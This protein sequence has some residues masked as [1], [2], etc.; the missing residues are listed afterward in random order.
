MTYHEETVQG[1]LPLLHTS[2]RNSSIVEVPQKVHRGKPS[3]HG[4]NT[5]DGLVAQK[6]GAETV[7][8]CGDAALARGVNH[9]GRCHAL[10]EAPPKR[11]Q[12]YMG[13]GKCTGEPKPMAT[14]GSHALVG[15][16][17]CRLQ[18]K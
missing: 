17:D 16:V 8:L 18:Q 5:K 4:I 9:G 1:I 10:S 12:M 13:S 11:F 2:I 3:R 14:E 7:A 6:P 15:K